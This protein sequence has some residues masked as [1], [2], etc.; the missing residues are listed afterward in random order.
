LFKWDYWGDSK[1]RILGHPEA[2][3]CMIP[4]NQN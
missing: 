1:D 2:V 4:Y 3:E